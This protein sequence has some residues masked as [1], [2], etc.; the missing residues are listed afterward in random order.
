VVLR[1]KGG[2]KNVGVNAGIGTGAGRGGVAWKQALPSLAKAKPCHLV[3]GR[4]TVESTLRLGAF[5][6]A[7]SQMHF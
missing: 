4:S 6:G 5:V 1:K 7:N 2:G 3:A